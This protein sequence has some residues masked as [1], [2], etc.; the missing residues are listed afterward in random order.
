[1]PPHP[2]AA[3]RVELLIGGLILALLLGIMIPVLRSTYQTSQILR[4]RQ[5]LDQM[6]KAV[7]TYAESYGGY[8]PLHGP[9]A[10]DPDWRDR[11]APFLYPEYG[12]P[13]RSTDPLWACPAGGSYAGNHN[14]FCPAPPQLTSFLLRKEV[15]VIADANDRAARTGVTDFDGVEWRHRG[16]TNV[17]LIDG[18]V[19]WVKRASARWTRRHWN[20]PQ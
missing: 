2:R 3:V 14:I 18:S 9:T 15:G 17:V 7:L 1:M 19:K 16:G 8:P 20:Q 13:P 5:Q 10:A 6:Y 12:A 4:C 11:I